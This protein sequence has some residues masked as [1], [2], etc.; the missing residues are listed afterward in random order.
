MTTSGAASQSGPWAL[1]V[2]HDVVERP[3]T[4]WTTSMAQPAA[5]LALATKSAAHL[6]SDRTLFS[7]ALRSPSGG[8]VALRPARRK[9]EFVQYHAV[10]AARLDLLEPLERRRVVSPRRAVE[11]LLKLGL[12]GGERLESAAV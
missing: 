1:F 10:A 12:D 8:S 5:A 6:S 3:L 11:T 9:I 7:T 2:A 4:G